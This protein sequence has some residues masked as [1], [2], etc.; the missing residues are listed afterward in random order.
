MLFTSLLLMSSAFVSAQAVPVLKPT[1]VTALDFSPEYI[2]N[3]NTDQSFANCEKVYE[4]MKAKNYVLTAA[5]EKTLSYCEETMESPWDII[6]G[7]C[8]WYCMG[9]G[10]SITASSY[11]KSQGKITY[12][13]YN[14]H[15]LDYSTAWVEGAAGTGKGEY[16]VYHFKE[17][18]NPVHTIIVVNGYVKSKE[19]WENNARVKKLRVYADNKAV[20]ILDLTDERAAQAF[21]VKL[22]GAAARETGSKEV[23]WT[24]KFEILDVYPGKKYEDAVITEIYFDG[25]SH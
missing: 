15:D 4:K 6:G 11:L 1:A 19:A 3:F 25:P 9:G 2:K 24:L 14:A 21:S 5:D 20:A 8:S 18:S 13:P 12:G 16:L 23:L 10:D 17:Q 22:P 7:G